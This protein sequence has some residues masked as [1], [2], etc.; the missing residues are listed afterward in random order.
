MPNGKVFG[1][2]ATNDLPLHEINPL[3]G[4]TARLNIS[5][6]SGIFAGLARWPYGKS[7][8]RFLALAGS[9]GGRCLHEVNLN[10]MELRKRFCFA[11]L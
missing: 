5:R 1:I 8:T 7:N 2:Q 6:T 4:A 3:T 9:T 10:T 11:K